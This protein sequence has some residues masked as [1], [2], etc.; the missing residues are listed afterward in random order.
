M[1]FLFKTFGWLLLGAIGFLG[2]TFGLSQFPRQGPSLGIDQIA[3]GIATTYVFMLKTGKCVLVDVGLDP[4]GRPIL[5]YLEKRGLR[6]SDVQAIFLTHAHTDH[7][8]GIEAFPGVSVFALRQ[9]VSLLEKKSEDRNPL[10]QIVGQAHTPLVHV[11]FPLEDQQT[12]QIEDLSIT[13]YSL[14]GHT[15]GSAVYLAQGVLLMGDTI[16]IGWG[17]RVRPPVWLFST[18][19]R[20]ARASMGIFL[21]HIRPRMGEVRVIAASHSGSI[22]AVRGFAALERY[23]SNGGW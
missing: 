14:P 22:D 18:D 6:A 15:P 5:D 21:D 11:T 7:I 4:T 9:E 10:R 17:G 2:Y 3:D 23:V 8:G 19:M 20:E 12:V 1:R 13:A 16:G